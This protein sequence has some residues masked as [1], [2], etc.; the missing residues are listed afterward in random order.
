MQGRP[1]TIPVPVAQ[2]K[3]A[4]DV[5]VALDHQEPIVV[6]FQQRLRDFSCVAAFND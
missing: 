3:D 1:A 6:G 5:A 4:S 2:D